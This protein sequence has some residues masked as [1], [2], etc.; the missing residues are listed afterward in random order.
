MQGMRDGIP[1]ALGY[2]AVALTLGLHARAAGLTLWQATLSS[3][4]TNASAGEYAGFQLI[5]RH[6]AL[7]EAVVMIAVINARYL[8]M[9]CALSQKLSPETPLWQ[10]LLLGHC[11][12]DEIFAI[13]I[14]QPDQLNPLY[15]Y[16][17]FS[18]ASPA[19]ALGTAMGV[20]LG[21][22]LPAPVVSALNVGLYGMFIAIVV[23]PARE[24]R[25]LACAVIVSMAAGFCMS[26]A[27]GISDGMKT[28]LLTV[29][30]SAVFAVL[31]PVKEENAHE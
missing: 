5:A 9:S 7:V 2:F 6:A 10:R 26:F 30:L 4:L 17:A 19:W 11:V 1:I 18:L 3:L 16:G 8:L 14:A 12:T 24:S 25:V 21:N 27:G 20:I 23:P 31:F 15:S 13:S 22:T 29:V 28:I